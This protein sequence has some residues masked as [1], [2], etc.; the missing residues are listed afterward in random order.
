MNEKEIRTEDI[1]K[2]ISVSLGKIADELSRIRHMKAEGLFDSF[3]GDVK[4]IK[5][6][7]KKPFPAMER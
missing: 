5:N 3:M 2:D 1:L 6:E 7:H 4:V